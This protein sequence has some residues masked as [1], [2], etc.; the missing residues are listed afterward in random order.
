MKPTT[1]RELLAA[2]ALITPLALGLTLSEA[3]EEHKKE[4][5]EGPKKPASHVSL[6]IPCGAPAAARTR[7]LATDFLTPV[8]PA[9]GTASPRA[10]RFAAAPPPA[11]MA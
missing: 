4:G 2:A 7:S 8:R 5:H 11:R 9:P 1:R 3:A 10:R 6:V